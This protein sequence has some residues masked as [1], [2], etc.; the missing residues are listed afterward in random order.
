MP[1]IENPK[2]KQRHAVAFHRTEPFGNTFAR[3]FAAQQ[4]RVQL[5]LR[6]RRE[7]VVIA[8]VRRKHQADI[9]NDVPVAKAPG[10]VVIERAVGDRRPGSDHVTFHA[11]II[12]RAR[13]VAHRHPLRIYKAATF[14]AAA[15]ALLIG[16]IEP[17]PELRLQRRWRQHGT[18]LHA[19]R[20]FCLGPNRDGHAGGIQRERAGRTRELGDLAVAGRTNR[21]LHRVIPGA[22]QRERG[23]VAGARDLRVRV[24]W[25][26]ED[27]PLARHVRRQVRVKDGSA[28]RGDPVNAGEG[29]EQLDLAADQVLAA[30]IQPHLGRAGSF[31]AIAPR[32][33]AFVVGFQ[34]LS[35]KA[36]E[37]RRQ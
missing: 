11:L 4:V 28:I 27:G 15:R 26:T 25:L 7:Q 9:V 24:R 35:G 34:G 14:L 6:F 10:Q 13:P 1:A 23:G 22:R 30:P 20:Q 21:Q 3:R 16:E 37:D 32:R 33:A 17:L 29:A 2:T 19:Q 31:A 5:I 8:R 18:L 36:A 12:A